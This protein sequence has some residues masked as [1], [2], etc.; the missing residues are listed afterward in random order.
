MQAGETKTSGYPA[1]FS[2]L[3]HAQLGSLS[4]FFFRPALLGSLFDG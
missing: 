4:D 1:F 2:T 3:G